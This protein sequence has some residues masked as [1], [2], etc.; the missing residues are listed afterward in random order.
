ME[1]RIVEAIRASRSDL[2]VQQPRRSI[3]SQLTR[4]DIIVNGSNIINHFPHRR[5]T[6]DV[7]DILTPK[8]VSP[9]AEISAL[10][11]FSS[12]HDPILIT[13]KTAPVG[14]NKT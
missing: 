1:V 2:K 8:N 10:L 6:P 7:L 14:L 12:D 13:G 4:I 3:S 5:V 11:Y 9:P